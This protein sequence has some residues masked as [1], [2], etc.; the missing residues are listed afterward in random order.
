MGRDGDSIY[1]LSRVEVERMELE[2]V[3]RALEEIRNGGVATFEIHPRKNPEHERHF[4]SRRGE[5][6]GACKGEKTEFIYVIYHIS[7]VVHGYPITKA[8]LRQ[9]GVDL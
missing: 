2:V 8:L 3:R 5:D 1:R 7:G 9:K 6:I 4:W